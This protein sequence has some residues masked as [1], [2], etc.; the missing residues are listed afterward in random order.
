M[1]LFTA[2]AALMAGTGY[3]LWR[4]TDEA[5]KDAAIKAE[6]D[7][8]PPPKSE[9]EQLS[10]TMRVDDLCL[11]L[12]AGL[13]I[14]SDSAEAALPGKIKS[15]R[16][17]FARDYGFVLPTV[18]IRD[19]ATLPA[20]R[21]RVLVQGVEAASGDLRGQGR[22]VLIPPGDHGLSGEPAKDPAFGLDALWVDSET[23][24]KAE[25]QGLTVVDPESVLTTHLTEV[26]KDHM[27]ELQNYGATREAVD[28]LDREYQKLVTD[29]SVPSP[30]ILVQ[31]VL[32]RLLAERVS[33]R[34][35]PLI[36]EAIAEGARGTSSVTKITEHVR[37]RL[38]NQICAQLDDGAGYVPVLAL[39]PAWE[40]EFVEAIRTGGDEPTF[41]MS[42]QRVQDFVLAA[43]QQIQA[44][45]GGDAWPAIL[46]NADARHF[47]RSMLER[48]SPTTPVIS[49][50]EI[51]RK[52]SLRT[53]GQIG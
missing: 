14:L 17:V 31:H 21:Y 51:H 30:M 7:D 32:Q 27:A 1:M 10:D 36:A 18:R 46:V 52:A 41:L 19:E 12:G 2:L 20:N 22:M 23:A 26:V 34:N 33:I 29:L 6:K 49:H 37:Q 43:R 35:L 44:H 39:S 38:A 50:A 15:L 13:V 42:P 25:A 11:E 53:V 9:A 47:V 5:E 45:A 40:K 3:V 8:A 4:K 16:G 48:V 28:R 24:D